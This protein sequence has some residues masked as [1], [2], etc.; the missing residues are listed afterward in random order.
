ML[1]LFRSLNTLEN[2]DNNNTRMD[3]KKAVKHYIFRICQHDHGTPL[4]VENAERER[5]LYYSLCRCSEMI[6]RVPVADL[7]CREGGGAG[8]GRE[9]HSSQESSAHFLLLKP[10]T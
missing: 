3:F 5:V 1:T 8:R 4:Q 7:G 9:S 10:Y 6:L 2:L